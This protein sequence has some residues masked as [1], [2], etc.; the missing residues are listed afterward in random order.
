MNDLKFK[1]EVDLI[2]KI[3]A[4]FK[5]FSERGLINLILENLKHS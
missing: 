1:D 2:I 3:V 5:D 4:Q